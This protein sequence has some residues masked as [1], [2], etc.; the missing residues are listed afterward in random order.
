MT[1]KPPSFPIRRRGILKG[2]AASA[3]AAPLTQLFRMHRSRAAGTGPVPKVVFFYTPCGVELPLWHPAQTG[4][5]FTLP[6]LSA[7]LAPYQNECIFMDGISMVPLTDHQGGSQQMLVGDDKDVKTLDL[8]LGDYMVS[9][10]D[11]SP[12]SSVQLGIQSRISKGGTPTVPHPHFTRISLAQEV[13]AEDNPLAAFGRIFGAGTS[14]PSTNV[15][16]L[17]RLAAQQK[18]ILDTATADLTALQKS[19]PGSEAMKVDAYATSLRNLERRLTAPGGTITTACDTTKF[20]PTGFTV[21]QVSDPNQAAYNQTAN[22]GVVADLQMEIARLSLACGRTRVVTLLYEHTNAHNPITGL[23]IYGVHDASHFNAPP[24]QL[25]GTATQAQ[26]DSKLMAWENYRVWYAQKL[27]QFIAMLKA[28]P[29]VTGTLFDNTIILHCSELGNG[30]PHK[31][32]RVPFVFIGGGALGFKLGQAIDFT[33]TVPAY[34]S[35]AHSGQRY[36][37]HSPLL[38]IVARK[39]GMPLPGAQFGFTGPQALDP[40]S[41]GIV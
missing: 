1:T 14:A 26:I 13:F 39:M 10:K 37:A 8:Q 19:L 30:G 36:M 7:P 34:T 4:T 9:I 35:G 27:A 40:M 23:G 2:L 28:T 3:L 22:R 31:T 5:T 21:P 24:G 33:N 20:N 11:P 25:T 41:L 15:A 16:A 12:F 6:R 32:D 38:T 29:D 17:A 18:S